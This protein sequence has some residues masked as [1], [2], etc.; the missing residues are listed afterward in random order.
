MTNGSIFPVR[1]VMGVAGGLRTWPKGAEPMLELCPWLDLG[2]APNSRGGT[3]SLSSISPNI[4]RGVV[5]PGRE[6]LWAPSTRS[7]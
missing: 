2:T 4:E 6:S 3:D 1:C 5:V 7:E